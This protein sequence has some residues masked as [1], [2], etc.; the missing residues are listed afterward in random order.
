MPL[1][2]L[3][4]G[5]KSLGLV[6]NVQHAIAGPPCVRH[7]RPVHI[8]LSIGWKEMRESRDGHSRC[9]RELRVRVTTYGR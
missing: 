7:Q 9:E 2:R 3:R 8:D 1:A 4:I 6:S 5:A